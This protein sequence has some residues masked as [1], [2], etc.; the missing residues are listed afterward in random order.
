MSNET[1]PTWPDGSPRDPRFRPSKT[2]SGWIFDGPEGAVGPFDLE[3]A[4][5]YERFIL[6]LTIIEQHDADPKE[7]DLLGD[8]DNAIEKHANALR[9]AQDTEHGLKLARQRWE[10]RHYIDRDRSCDGCPQAP[11]APKEPNGS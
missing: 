11:Q 9:Q 4:R 7:Q 5:N 3:G 6:A 8:Y 1:W 2:G 10:R